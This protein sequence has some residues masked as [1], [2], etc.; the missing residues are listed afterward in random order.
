MTGF[1]DGVI[2]TALICFTIITL[3]ILGGWFNDK[4]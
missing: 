2:I 3:R 4:D 1:S